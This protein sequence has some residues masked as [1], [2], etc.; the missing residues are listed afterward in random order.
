MVFFPSFAFQFLCSPP[1]Y[2]HL[3][4]T[5]KRAVCCT[6]LCI[7]PQSHPPGPG[8]RGALPPPDPQP[9]QSALLRRSLT[10]PPEQSPG[11]E[12]LPRQS[13]L[14]RQS[15][16]RCGLPRRSH[17]QTFAQ[18][19]CRLPGS[20]GPFCLTAKWSATVCRAV[21]AA[22]GSASAVQSTVQQIPK[23]RKEM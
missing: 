10:A 21:R 9:R 12:A 15:H 3:F 6:L 11:G 18:Q 14:L 1:G 8:V 19:S 16:P 23:Q 17:P 2:S 13:T 5:Q 22:S 4:I 7:H 20:G